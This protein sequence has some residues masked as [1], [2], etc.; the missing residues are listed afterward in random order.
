VIFSR[1]MKCNS[2]HLTLD[3]GLASDQVALLDRSVMQLPGRPIYVTLIRPIDVM[4]LGR[5]KHWI[6]RCKKDLI[7]QCEL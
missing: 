1:R 4:P 2:Y 3:I 7:V 6:A 5:G